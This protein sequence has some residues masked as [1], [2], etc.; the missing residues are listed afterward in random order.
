MLTRKKIVIIALIVFSLATATTAFAVQRAKIRLMLIETVP[1]LHVGQQTT[2]IL[3][4]GN[5]GGFNAVNAHAQCEY[6]DEAT[7]RPK[8]TP[9]G[10][11]GDP[12]DA[13]VV[14]PGQFFTGSI[15]FV[16][17]APARIRGYCYIAYTDTK[18]GQMTTTRQVRWSFRIVG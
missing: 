4:W 15:T 17:S 10:A 11:G 6:Y 18:T 7:D 14:A 3:H 8:L 13:A 12:R 1:V 5:E 9:I 16:A 2:L